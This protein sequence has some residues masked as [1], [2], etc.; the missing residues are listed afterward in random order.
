MVDRYSDVDEEDDREKYGNNAP[1]GEASNAMS[2]TV[3]TSIEVQPAK[4]T[5]STLDLQNELEQA[6]REIDELKK[7]LGDI[8]AERH[9]GEISAEKHE[10]GQ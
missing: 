7:Q 8:V 2:T 10:G 3:P 4:K 9:A 1:M 5:K 6:R